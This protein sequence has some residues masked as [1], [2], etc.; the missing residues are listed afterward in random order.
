MLASTVPLG[1]MSTEHDII[2]RNHVICGEWGM[3][4]TQLYSNN[5]AL[6]IPN[7]RKN[8]LYKAYNCQVRQNPTSVRLNRPNLESPAWKDSA[9]HIKTNFLLIVAIC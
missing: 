3:G 4:F 2:P 6:P 5:I 8:S 1:I 9:K 7:K